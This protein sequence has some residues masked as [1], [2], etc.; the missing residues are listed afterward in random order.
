MKWYD[1]LDT[2]TQRDIYSFFWDLIVP[3]SVAGVIIICALGFMAM[4]FSEGGC[5]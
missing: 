4:L 3:I 2:Q 1:E 5:P